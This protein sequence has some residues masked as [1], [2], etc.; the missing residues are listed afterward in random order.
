MNSLSEAVRP[1]FAEPVR[2]FRL[3]LPGII[4][5]MF[6]AAAVV[7]P[8]GLSIFWLVVAIMTAYQAYLA[9]SWNVVAGYAG[10]L[11]LGNAVFVT[12]GAYTSTLLAIHLGVTPWIGMWA[13]ALLATAAGTFAGWVFFRAR[14]SGLAFAL[15]TFALSQIVLWFIIG[16]DELGG[17]FGFRVHLSF[18]IEDFQF[19]DLIGYYYVIL[20]MLAAC[21]VITWRLR[22]GRLGYYFVAIREDQVAAEA[23]GINLVKYKTIAFAVSAGLSALGGS[24]LAQY[25][26]FVAPELLLKPHALLVPIV[27]G[28]FGGLGTTLGPVVGAGILVPLAHWMRSEYGATVPGIDLILYGIVLIGVMVLFP[29]GVVKALSNLHKRWQDMRRTR[30]LSQRV[31]S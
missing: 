19:R 4:L 13:G 30:R 21:L 28:M 6:L 23:L 27:V 29:G 10:Q 5:V 12:I 8:R 9:V 22:R 17:R 1:I 15:G 14:L 16:S 7:A 26:L 18:E 2:R 3:A 31:G 25:L 20:A 24:F 11:S